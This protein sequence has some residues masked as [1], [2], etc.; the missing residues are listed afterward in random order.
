MQHIYRRY[1][2][3]KFRTILGCL[4]GLS[5]QETLNQCPTGVVPACDNSEDSVTVSGP[6]DGVKQFIKELQD[7]G[8]FAKAVECAGVP[9]HSYFMKEAA[10][11]LK[12]ALEKVC[13]T[14]HFHYINKTMQCISPIPIIYSKNNR[15]VRWRTCLSK[16]SYRQ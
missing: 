1:I 13:E 8:V 16:F 3:S 9:F 14:L 4:T 7:K 6:L 5:W 10:P 12:S 11:A 15:V 2:V